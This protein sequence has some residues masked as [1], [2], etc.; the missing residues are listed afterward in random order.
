MVVYR[1]ASPLCKRDARRRGTAINQT[2]AHTHSHTH[3][4]TNFITM[5][6]RGAGASVRQTQ[7]RT[8]PDPHPRPPPSPFYCSTLL[9]VVAPA[10]ESGRR[11]RKLI[12]KT[13]RL[14]SVFFQTLLILP[15]CIETC[16]CIDFKNRI[17]GLIGHLP[18]LTV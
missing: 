4:H 2:T 17:S 5:A 13:Q 6:D 10:S 15:L 7:E 3:S 1:S 11:S 18:S 9:A 14:Q 12:I 16:A 8:C